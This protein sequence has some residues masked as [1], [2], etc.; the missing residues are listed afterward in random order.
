MKDQSEIYLTVTNEELLKFLEFIPSW[1]HLEFIEFSWKKFTGMS[2]FYTLTIYANS[3]TA[4]LYL[5]R[6]MAAKGII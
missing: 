5:G 3:G 2:S 1:V 4:L 6:D